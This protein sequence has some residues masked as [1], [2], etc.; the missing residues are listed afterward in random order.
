M[1]I[2]FVFI[3]YILQNLFIEKIL[4]AGEEGGF[5]NKRGKVL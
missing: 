3:F 4:L 5:N 2:I 1:Q